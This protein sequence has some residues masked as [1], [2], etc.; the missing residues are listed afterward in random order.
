MNAEKITPAQQVF[1]NEIVNGVSQKQAYMAAYPGSSVEAAY[2]SASRLMDKPH[3]RRKIDEAIDEVA[4]VK[5]EIMIGQY[6]DR[7]VSIARQRESLAAAYD[8]ENTRVEIMTNFK[9][10]TLRKACFDLRHRIAAIS[11]DSKLYKEW[12]ELIKEIN[13]SVMIGKVMAEIHTLKEPALTGAVDSHHPLFANSFFPEDEVEGADLSNFEN[14]HENLAILSKNYQGP[15][16]F[17]GKIT[18]DKA[19]DLSNVLERDYDSCSIDYET[20]ETILGEP[21]EE[22]IVAISQPVHRHMNRRQR[23]QLEHSRRKLAEK[24]EKS[25]ILMNS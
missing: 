11:L 8:M 4:R 6:A 10:Q 17:P 15:A 23:R 21:G 22:E 19:T 1:I 18:S 25:H 5:Q 24:E 16:A 2:S 12:N 13:D 9:G 7:L 3:I 14:E 20:D